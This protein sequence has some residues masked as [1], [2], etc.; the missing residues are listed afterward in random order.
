MIEAGGEFGA[1]R[2]STLGM[3]RIGVL[4]GRHANFRADARDAVLPSHR[5][6]GRSA[7]G[8]EVALTESRSR[9]ASWVLELISSFLKMLRR[10]NAIV[11]G[12]RN[13]WD[14][15]S[16]PLTDPQSFGLFPD[17]PMPW[18]RRSSA[19]VELSEHR[20]RKLRGLLDGLGVEDAPRPRDV[21]AAVRATVAQPKTPESVARTRAVIEYLGPARCS[22]FRGFPPLGAAGQHRMRPSTAPTGEARSRRPAISSSSPARPSSTTPICSSSSGS[23]CDRRLSW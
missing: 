23:A 21:L 9:R 5:P 15:A 18:A 17:L 8:A 1:E 3:N 4:Q 22:R 14:A 16:R 19:V 6:N 7:A 13:S 11:R 10:W 2:C 20:L 12:L